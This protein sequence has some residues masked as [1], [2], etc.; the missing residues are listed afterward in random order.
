MTHCHSLPSSQSHV[1]SFSLTFFYPSTQWGV[2][3]A[4]LP[5]AFEKASPEFGSVYLSAAYELA[6]F[7]LVAGDLSTTLIKLP[8]LPCLLFFSITTGATYATALGFVPMFLQPIWAPVLV[9]VFA[10]GRFVEAHLLTV[11]FVTIASTFPPSIKERSTRF[12]GLAD[13]FCISCGSVVSSYAVGRWA[14]S[15]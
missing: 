13:I 15:C 12:V 6:T 3:P 9:I 7:T 4:V 1:V 2:I 8:R 11:V 10:L 5:F 14:Q